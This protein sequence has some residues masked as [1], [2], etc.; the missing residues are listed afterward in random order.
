MTVIYIS[1]ALLV[2]LYVGYRFGKHVE[3]K[4]I[5]RVLGVPKGYGITGVSYEKVE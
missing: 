4:R 3:R 2:G 5:V 1:I